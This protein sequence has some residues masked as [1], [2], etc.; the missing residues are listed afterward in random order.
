[1]EKRKIKDKKLPVGFTFSFPCQQS[2]IDE[3]C[4]FWDSLPPQIPR[5]ERLMHPF[6]LLLFP[7]A[8]RWLACLV[9]LEIN[10]RS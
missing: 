7:L 10:V 3:V 4:T 2:K 8:C 9:F 5:V 6:S 1:M